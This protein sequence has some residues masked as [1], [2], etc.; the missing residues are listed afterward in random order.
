MNRY[1]MQLRDV[2]PHSRRWTLESFT[3]KYFGGEPVN[4]RVAREFWSDFRLG[5]V[6]SLTR[7]IRE[8]T[9]VI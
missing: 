3:K 1:A 7:Y 9:E 4:R 5:Y 8:T 2:N 6:G